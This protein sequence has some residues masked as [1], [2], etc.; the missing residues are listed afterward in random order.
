MIDFS[1]HLLSVTVLFCCICLLNCSPQP[2]VSQRQP[3]TPTTSIDGKSQKL[4]N[5]ARK[6]S[7]LGKREEALQKYQQVLQKNPGFIDAYL[8]R[9][10]MYYEMEQWEDAEA[11]FERALSLDPNNALAHYTLANVYKA[12]RKYSATVDQLEVFLQIEQQD[13]VRILRALELLPNMIFADS[14]TQNPLPFDPIKLSPEINTIYSE[15]TPAL[16][17]DGELLI[18]TRR[19]RGQED[20][21]Q[22][23]LQN[24]SVIGTAEPI[25]ILNTPD[26][27]GAHTLSADGTF[28]VFTACNRPTGYGL[29]D[30]YYSKKIDGQWTPAVSMGP[31][32]NSAASDTEP[33]LTPD[34]KGLYFSSDRVGGLG[35]KDIWYTQRM[36]DGKW[37]VPVNLG[38][39]INTKGFEES[40]FIHH[41]GVTLYFRSN[42]Y[43]GMGSTD[44]Y[45]SR[46][47][48]G[49]SKPANL[50]YPINTEGTDGSL[51]VSLDG[52]WALYSSDFEDVTSGRDQRDTDIYKFRLP[53]H[54]R[55]QRVS[56]VK[57]RIYSTETNE[58]LAAELILT[59]L[60]TGKDRMT[61]Q[62]NENGEYFMTLPL[63]T[64]YAWA[65]DHP[66]Y[67]FY[68]NHFDLDSVYGQLDPFVYDIGLTEVPEAPSTSDPTI[69]ETK[70]VVLQNIFFETGSATLL[71]SSNTE[72]DRLSN[73]LKEY[74]ESKV[75]IHGHTDNI[76]SESDNLQLSEMRAEAIKR[77]LTSRAIEANRITTKGFGESSPIS[78]N[79][80]AEGR[81]LNRRVEFV[82]VR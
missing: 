33:S 51:T 49:W 27:E 34:G 40:P 25:V 78:T 71:P 43:P 16:S 57:G 1:K 75:Y 46:W 31:R 66:G 12:Q 52:E 3:E 61:V 23:R 81:R 17:G 56:Y 5:E 42:G 19:Y 67:I 39:A 4:F 63:G 14:A 38:A 28:M 2:L 18:F 68:S 29:C 69:K 6:L 21:Y 45:L 55:P 9:G 30:L 76:G 44:L 13:S 53:N 8:Y 41:D 65:V 73:L 60:T 48:D 59:D 58:P 72:I 35:G 74:P 50:G 10:G 37:H 36:A 20:F 15:Y 79:E 77:A 32:V 11:D 64:T 80:T 47:D 62:A 82:L 54:L 26:N 7:R 22:V 24:D 70:P